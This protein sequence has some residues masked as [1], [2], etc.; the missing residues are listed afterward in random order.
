ML[1]VM[2]LSRFSFLELVSPVLSRAREP[3]PTAVRTLD[4][5]HLASVDFLRTMGQQLAMATF[6][7][8]VAEAATALGIPLLEP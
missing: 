8:R 2:L 1:D 6:D 4:A 7:R 3:F 5:M